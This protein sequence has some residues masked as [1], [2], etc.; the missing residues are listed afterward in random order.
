M[1]IA[2]ILDQRTITKEG[3]HPIKF[4]FTEG[5]KSTYSFTGFYAIEDE[6]S[7]ETF[8]ISKDKRSRR[9]NE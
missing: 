7:P 6:F 2:I 1:K 5:T 9:M 4:R 3:K 8:F